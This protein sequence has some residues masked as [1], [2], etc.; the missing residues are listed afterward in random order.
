MHPPRRKFAVHSLCWV[1]GALLPVRV[2]THT[3]TKHLRAGE[4]GR[5]PDA[6]TATSPR[7][8]RRRALKLKLKWAWMASCSV[9]VMHHGPQDS[10]HNSSNHGDQ[11]ASVV[12]PLS[13]DKNCMNTPARR[14]QCSGGV[15]QRCCYFQ[16]DDADGLQCC[17]V[18]RQWGNGVRELRHGGGR[19]DEWRH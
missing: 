15:G 16:V 9:C 5:R 6:Q 13:P 12:D 2:H 19:M 8:R 7:A 1:C 10:R 3:L 18:S 11:N 17:S 4:S 14:L